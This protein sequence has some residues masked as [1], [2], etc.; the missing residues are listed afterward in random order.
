MF[1]SVSPQCAGISREACEAFV[2]KL[3]GPEFDLHS[4]I[5]ARGSLIFAEG[6]RSPFGPDSLHRMYS[7]TK[8]LVGVAAGLLAEEGK[9]DLDAPLCSYFPDK[10]SAGAGPWL[11]AQ[12]VRQT[13]TMQTSVRCPFWIDER[14]H[15]RV[16]LY[17]SQP[18]HHPAGTSFAYD[19]D[20]SQ[21]LTSLIERVSG[22]TLLGFLRER[23]FNRMGAFQTARMLTVPG[24]DSWGDGG[25]LATTRDM[26]AFARLVMDRGAWEGEQ[27]MSADYLKQATSFQ[28]STCY[29]A[30]PVCQNFG[31]GYHFWITERG[32]FA[33][34]GLG[35][36]LTICQPD[37]DLIFCC[38]A[39]HQ[40]NDPAHEKLFKAFFE[41]ICDHIEEELLPD[42]AKGP[43][44]F[45]GSLRAV[46]GFESV[47]L[48]EKIN[49]VKYLCSENR[50]GIREFSFSFEEDA[51]V[52]NYV[53][54]QGV[55][56]MRCG[57]GRCLPGKFPEYG[58]SRLV[59]GEKSIAR[60]LYDAQFSAAWVSDSQLQ[61][62]VQIVDMYIGNMTANFCFRDKL[63]SVVMMKNAYDFLNEYWGEF[64]AEAK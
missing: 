8:S 17:F 21:V 46:A 35:D 7:Q 41:M 12:T 59:G 10:L 27:L 25:L 31:Y 22:K 39:D 57:L 4:L 14:E 56:R 54:A 13:L 30:N 51:V 19:T 50:T 55:K 2:R 15:D 60:S 24:G 32:G 49:G 37:L 20:G 61:L 28:V 47:P 38:T 29:N 9:I 16:K 45:G 44:S 1:Q 63:C 40:G 62:K 52:F 23:L 58:Y 5:L 42:D 64:T 53:N 26:L 3:S 11:R 48:A 43:V 33:C 36:Q 34:V 18:D 6:Y